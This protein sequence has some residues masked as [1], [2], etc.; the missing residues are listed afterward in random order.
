MTLVCP[1]NDLDVLELLGHL[2]EG[3]CL[4]ELR[5][6]LKQIQLFDFIRVVEFLT[7][8]YNLS[9]ELQLEIFFILWNL[10]SFEF[11]ELCF[12]KGFIALLLPLHYL[13]YG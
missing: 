2:C 3:V 10:L 6:T 7:G 1:L 11:V 8:A 12:F 5:V 13:S 9:H 4:V